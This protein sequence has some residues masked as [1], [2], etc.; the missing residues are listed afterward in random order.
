[1]MYTA[2]MV[3]AMTAS[4]FAKADQEVAYYEVGRPV[5]YSSPISIKL[6]IDTK[7]VGNMSSAAVSQVY[8]VTINTDMDCVP[9]V[10]VRDT[11]LSWIAQTDGVAVYD[12]GNSFVQNSQYVTSIKIGNSTYTPNLPYEDDALDGFYF[13]VNGRIPLLT[14]SSEAHAYGP[15]GAY[16]Y[17]TPIMMVMLSISTGIIRIIRHLIRIIVQTMFQLRRRI[18]AAQIRL[19]FSL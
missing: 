13:R 9:G 5:A 15:E 6:V 8:D 11:I 2:I 19:V 18:T 3:M 1:M 17:Q 16:V 7:K 14:T 10:T 12:H 4:V